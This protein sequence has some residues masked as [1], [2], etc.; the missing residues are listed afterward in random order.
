MDKFWSCKRF[1]RVCGR[2]GYFIES[3]HEEYLR[4]SG[5]LCT[6]SKAVY[7]KLDYTV[8]VNVIMG[9]NGFW[10]AWFPYVACVANDATMA[11]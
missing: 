6:Y 10:V 2:A 5:P 7:Y 11:Y 1:A 4:Y 8:T 3:K 9:C